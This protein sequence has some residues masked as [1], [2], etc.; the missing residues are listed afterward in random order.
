MAPLISIDPESM[1]TDPSSAPVGVCIDWLEPVKSF[2]L[3]I[4]LYSQKFRLFILSYSFFQSFVLYLFTLI[5]LW[6]FSYCLYIFETLTSLTDKFTLDMSSSSSRHYWHYVLWLEVL[7]LRF[8]PI[9]NT[10][11]WEM[12]EKKCCDLNGK[13]A[14]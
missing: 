13:M 10:I 11:P 1:T 6:D 4:L 7:R 5:Y 14:V 3:F 2:L 12:L 8:L 9:T